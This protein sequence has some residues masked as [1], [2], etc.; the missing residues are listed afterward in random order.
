[1]VCVLQPLWA[2]LPSSHA[3]CSPRDI[4]LSSLSVQGGSCR[5]QA[6]HVLGGPPICFTTDLTPGPGA[7]IR[8]TPSSSAHSLLA[9]FV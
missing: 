4:F 3:G 6:V 8:N 9:C 5:L 2:S 1:M 7:A